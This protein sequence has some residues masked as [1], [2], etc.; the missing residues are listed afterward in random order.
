M[1]YAK[2]KVNNRKKR[3]R[4]V[5]KRVFGTAERPRLCVRRSLKH[6][7]AQIINDVEG[8]AL[9]QVGSAGKEAGQKKG[10]SKAD[11]AKAVGEL[12]AVKALEKGITK[13]VFDRKGYAY[14]GRIKV[15][16]DAARAK[17]LSF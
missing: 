2:Q 16:A 3:A 8:K 13:V 17:G 11:V 14:Q 9:V 10:G 7:Y 4:R 12:V 1:D 5:R 15:L 6:I